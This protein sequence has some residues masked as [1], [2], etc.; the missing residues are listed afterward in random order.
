MSMPVRALPTVQNWDC[1]SCSDCC[2]TYSV[3]VTDSERLTIA[4]QNWSAEPGFEKIETVVKGSGGYTLAHT[5]EGACVFLGDDKLCRIHAKFGEPAKPKACRIYPF[6]LVPVGGQWRVGIRFACP[7]VTANLGR[8]LAQHTGAIDEYARL[9][10]ADAAEPLDRL[11]TPPLRAGLT[12]PWD[13]LLRFN[14]AF[15]ELLNEPAYSLERRLRQIAALADVCKKAS[16][17]EVRGQRLTEFLD[18]MA[19]TLVEEVPIRAMVPKPSWAGRMLFRQLAAIYCRKDNGPDTGIASRS[20]W[21]RIR[22]AW[23]F[24]RGSGSIPRLHAKIPDV[25]FADTEEPAGPILPETE[26]L[27]LRYYQ[28]KLESLQF[29]GPTNYHRG[30]WEGL[31]ALLMTFPVVLWLTRVFSKGSLDRANAAKLALRL[32]DDSFGFNKLLDAGRQPW[33]MRTLGDRGE[34]AKLIARYAG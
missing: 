21:V 1:R 18:V 4:K 7:T 12:L 2:R 22:S 32:V 33:A 27:L 17:D 5:A 26:A 20:R 14:A 3:P 13:E 16:F 25:A 24:A 8:N 19:A 9:M 15:L 11:P 23:R 28:V 29:C 30:Y 31:D 6:L 34:V 10:E